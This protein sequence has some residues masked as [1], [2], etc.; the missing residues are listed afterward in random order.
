MQSHLMKCVSVMDFVCVLLVT[1]AGITFVTVFVLSGLIT[2]Q[3]VIW[4]KLFA[5]KT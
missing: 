1:D 4:L 3:R 2:G 5:K